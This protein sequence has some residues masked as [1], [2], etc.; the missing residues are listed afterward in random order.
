[1]SY[2]QSAG[3]FEFRTVSEPILTDDNFIY[4][5]TNTNIGTTFNGNVNS[6]WTYEETI[7]NG[8][9]EPF[10]A[11]VNTWTGSAFH[12]PAL[13]YNHQNVLDTVSRNQNNDIEV[14]EN[15]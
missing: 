4:Y 3:T 12:P 8:H 5:Q 14:S 7:N 9:F 6:D 1:M 13:S 11:A 10:T 2:S 15:G